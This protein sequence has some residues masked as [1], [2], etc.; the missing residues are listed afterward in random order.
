MCLVPLLLLLLLLHNITKRTEANHQTN[1]PTDRPTD[2]Q[3]GDQLAGN[4]QPV[5]RAHIVHDAVPE[6]SGAKCVQTYR[7]VTETSGAGC[8][9]DAD[10]S[11][12]SLKVCY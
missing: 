7:H 5:I 2:R 8:I 12:D 10:I 4:Q 9:N 6:H 3:T 1:R 11:D